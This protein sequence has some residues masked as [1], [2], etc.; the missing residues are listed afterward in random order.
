MEKEIGE[1]HDVDEYRTVFGE[2]IVIASISA[3]ICEQV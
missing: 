2:W 1:W 3:Y